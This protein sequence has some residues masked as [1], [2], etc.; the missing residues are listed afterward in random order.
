MRDHESCA[1]VEKMLYAQSNRLAYSQARA[2]K[3][4]VERRVVTS[5]LAQS[6]LDMARGMAPSVKET[7][8]PIP[9]LLYQK[10]GQAEMK[11]I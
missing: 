8:S 5:R 9:P 10:R 2:C 11:V 1:V 7:T 6:N 4:G 3:Q